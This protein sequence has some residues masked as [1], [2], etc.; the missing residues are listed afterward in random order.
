MDIRNE[1]VSL[2]GVPLDSM[3]MQ[4]TVSRI[5]AFISEGGFHQI[6]TANVNF[7]VN[8]LRI[9]E[10]HRVL[11]Q[12]DLVVP[13]GVPLLWASRLVGQPL[14]ERVTG[15]DLVP[16]LADLSQRKGYSIYFLG[17][18]E[19][20]SSR[21]VDR[22]YEMYPGMNVA[23]RHCPPVV[24]L[25]GMDSIDIIRKINAA[26][27]DILLVAFGNPKQDLWL[28]RHRNAIKVPV[29]I[30]IGGT[31]EMIAGKVD[32]APLWMQKCGLEWFYRVAQEPR[33]LAGRYIRDFSGLAVPLGQQVLG[34]VL[35]SSRRPLRDV[36]MIHYG[37]ITLLRLEGGLQATDMERICD[38]LESDPDPRRHL[39]LDMTNVNYLGADA[40]AILM[41]LASLIH[42]HE[43][44][45]WLTGLSEQMLQIL[46]P[47]NA[48]HLLRT[49]K[50]SHVVVE[51]FP[52]A[53]RRGKYHGMHAHR[54]LHTEALRYQA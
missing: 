35:Q 20:N 14:K 8:A 43:G 9:P 5:E 31:L 18:T 49:A 26:K 24:T 40:L 10:L 38:M 6:A 30:G 2:V 12:C 47:S 46:R 4:D 17:A 42:R 23:G 22:L 54:L 41:R 44:T 21:A 52:S 37:G 53:T 7:L 25:D 45:L 28:A 3:T 29:A 19:D 50:N 48:G 1:C 13:D 11:S 16:N 36:T 15:V 32:R 39:L 27:P 33:R 34:M 51:R